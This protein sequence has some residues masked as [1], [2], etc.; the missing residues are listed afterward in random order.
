MEILDH[1]DFMK[2]LIGY[3]PWQDPQQAYVD[4]YRALD[5]DWIVSIPSRFVRFRPGETSRT[6]PDGTAYSEWGLSGSSWRR[7]YLFHDIESV[8]AFD[9]V[10]NEEN[11]FL[12]TPAANAVRLQERRE[13]QA[14]M[15]DSA[16]VTGIYYTT[17]FQF[18][19]MAFDWEL[20]LTA[21]A[22]EP[23]RFQPVLEGFAEVS[24]RNLAEWAAEPI[25]LIFMHDD[26][27]M[28][29]GLVFRP[30]WYRERLFPLYE[31]LLEPLK[32]RP[33]LK[34]A[35]VSD[36]NYSEVLDDLVALGFDGFVV[37]SGIDLGMVARRVGKR[38]FV[39]GN[40]STSVLTLGTPS[41]VVEE[42]RRCLEDARPAGGHFIHAGGDLP[43][44]IPLDNIRA[45]FEAAAELSARENR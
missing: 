42:V 7:D 2:E 21:A 11:E 15:G 13:G 33:D 8:L 30:E 6:D 29:R 1:P 5:V 18:G 10:V 27:A 40:V 28:E 35:F 20:F 44:N 22:S 43:H 37:N 26:I 23:D 9:P 34:V 12:V 31:Y 32:A 24:R 39:A 36:G 38:G 25:D 17:L 4:A 45:Y 3:D 16:L 14:L 19:I 41:D